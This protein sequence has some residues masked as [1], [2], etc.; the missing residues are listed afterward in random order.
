MHYQGEKLV[1]NNVE[2]WVDNIALLQT[3]RKKDQPKHTVIKICPWV[4]W[5]VERYLLYR[6]HMDVDKI[7]LI[8]RILRNNDQ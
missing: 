3:N 8:E 1:T 6:E 2:R 4:F 7:Q 5:S